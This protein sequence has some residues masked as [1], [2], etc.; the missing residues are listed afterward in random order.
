MAFRL[1]GESFAALAFPPL[2]PPS[3][4]NATAAGFFPA[5]GFSSGVPSICSPMAFSTTL[6]AFTAKSRSVLERLGMNQ[7]YRAGPK[8]KTPAN[9]KLTH[10][11]LVHNAGGCGDPLD[12]NPNNIQHVM[13]HAGCPIFPRPM[14]KG[15]EPPQPRAHRHKTKFAPGA[16]PVPCRCVQLTPESAQ[17][18]RRQSRPIQPALQ[19]RSAHPCP[20]VST[21]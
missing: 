7:V 2:A 11:L 20:T 19:A 14:R 15:W 4:P 13:R 5:L 18:N 8:P 21:T 16:N 12:W 17:S 3:L 6:S 1:S 9:F 10:Y